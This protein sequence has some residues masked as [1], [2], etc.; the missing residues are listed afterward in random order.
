MFTIVTCAEDELAARV[1]QH[2][3]KRALA[4]GSAFDHVRDNV[5]TFQFV[6]LEGNPGW[7]LNRDL[8]VILERHGRRIG[9]H[10]PRDLKGNALRAYRAVR[11]AQ[12]LQHEALTI[13][14]IAYDREGRSED[15]MLIA[16][17]RAAAAR[18]VVVAEAEPEF[19][20]WVLCGFVPGNA[21]EQTRLAEWVARLAPRGVHPLTTPEALTSNVNGDERDAKALVQA[22]LGLAAQ[23]SGDEPRVLDCLD[24]PLT[25]LRSN[26]A[27]TGLPE[28]LEQACHVVDATQ[29]PG[30][31][32]SR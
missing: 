9:I 7:T 6:G 12:T 31:V 13:L 5:A 15:Q 8:G 10:L 17:V 24:R 25:D 29:R 22:I 16:G 2:L 28:F 11:F 23:A 1:S 19:D 21:V 26:G 30:T 27:R 20:A 14:V 3:F 4:E 18:N 32:T